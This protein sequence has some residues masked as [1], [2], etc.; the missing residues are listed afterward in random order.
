MV[1]GL[2]IFFDQGLAHADAILLQPRVDAVVVDIQ[3]TVF[4]PAI[5][6]IIDEFIGVFGVDANIIHILA[7]RTKVHFSN[8]LGW[9]V[10]IIPLYSFIFLL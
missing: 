4:V 6:A 3:E 8:G 2:L 9:V 5:A 10:I 1:E 7:I